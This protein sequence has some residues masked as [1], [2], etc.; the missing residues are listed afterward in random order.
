MRS[1][2]SL[3]NTQE[4]TVRLPPGT[5]RPPPGAIGPPAPV[6]RWSDRH[7][8]SVQP[9]APGAEALGPVLDTRGRVH[10]EAAKLLL[11]THCL[12]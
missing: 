2:A 8:R 12:C 4:Q 9:P 3:R 10:I 7:H 5:I 6:R 11:S 1:G